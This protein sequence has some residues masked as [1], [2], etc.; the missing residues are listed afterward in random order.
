MAPG[1]WHP[2]RRPAQSH[3]ARQRCR[4]A[5][6]DP[7]AQSG[8]PR[9]TPARRR[10]HRAGVAPRSQTPP[11]RPLVRRP[12]GARGAWG[13]CASSATPGRRTWRATGGAS[14][15]MD[16]VVRRGGGGGMGSAVLAAVSVSPQ[17]IH[18]REVTRGPLLRSAPGRFAPRARPA[19]GPDRVR[20]TASHSRSGAAL[21][22]SAAVV[23]A[24]GGMERYALRDLSERGEAA[25]GGTP[26][27]RCGRSQ[28]ARIAAWP[29][30][31]ACVA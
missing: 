3:P 16:G 9:A 1:G 11:L 12:P 14:H 17:P 15:A 20:G 2:S 24:A 19:R 26:F 8:A 13:W 4:D 29:R 6:G 23:A 30:C 27:P 18:A 10:R 31:S 22:A 25:R 28:P 5:A 21:R 7:R